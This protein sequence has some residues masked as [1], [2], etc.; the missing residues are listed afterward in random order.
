[1]RRCEI[2]E[3]IGP[4]VVAIADWAVHTG[5]VRRD[6]E[7]QSEINGHDAPRRQMEVW[8]R[9]QGRRRIDHVRIRGGAI[10][11]GNHISCAEDPIGKDGP[12]RCRGIEDVV[13]D[14]HR[15]GFRWREVRHASQAPASRAGST[16]APL[17]EDVVFDRDA[18]H[19]NR[20]VASASGP[21]VPQ[22]DVRL[23]GI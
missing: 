12:P 16:P 1:S 11:V 13:C 21:S 17:M 15:Y 14:L 2:A 18:L 9:G 10:T 3:F 20:I 8:R 19:G 6:A 5:T 23:C 22:Y 7:I 4:Y